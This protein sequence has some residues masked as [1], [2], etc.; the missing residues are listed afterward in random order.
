MMLRQGD[1]LPVGIWTHTAVS[2]G[3]LAKVPEQGALASL[4]VAA[5]AHQ[6][7]FWSGRGIRESPEGKWRAEPS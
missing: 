3:I 4:I 1:P 5:Q 7:G 6:G 2:V